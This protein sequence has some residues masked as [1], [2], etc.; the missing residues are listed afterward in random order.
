[1]LV[2]IRKASSI[3]VHLWPTEPPFSVFSPQLGHIPK[4]L[5]PSPLWHSRYA[6]LCCARNHRAPVLRQ[7]EREREYTR[8][9]PELDVFHIALGRYKCKLPTS[10]EN[11]NAC[12][13]YVHEER[14]AG[15]EILGGL[16]RCWCRN[17]VLR[18]LRQRLLAIIVETTTVECSPKYI[19][20]YAFL[21]FS[22]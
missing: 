1:M 7:G 19:A 12:D 2:C 21:G 13:N 8:H 16:M 17:G 10:Y 6:I 14:L 15:A 18:R 11:Y 9:R 4:T 5:Q 3:E 22:Q 20:Q